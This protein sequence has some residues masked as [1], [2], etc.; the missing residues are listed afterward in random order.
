MTCVSD[1]TVE[2]EN[3]SLDVFTLDLRGVLMNDER[4]VMYTQRDQLALY[5][6]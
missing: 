4:G 3:G 5:N 2:R 1:G 6:F